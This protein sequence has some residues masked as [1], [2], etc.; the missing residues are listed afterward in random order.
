MRID[1]QG[2]GE[3]VGVGGR[4]PDLASETADTRV[5]QHADSSW[6]CT[7]L[8][9]PAFPLFFFL[10]TKPFTTDKYILIDL[11]SGQGTYPSADLQPHPLTSRP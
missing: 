3:T 5:R 2:V 6:L 9:L 7:Y 4:L 10:L 11:P 1:V 8:R